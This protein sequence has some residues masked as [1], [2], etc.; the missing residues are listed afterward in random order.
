[1]FVLNL[2]ILE[3]MICSG[4]MKLI[5]FARKK[6]RF[7]LY[8]IYFIAEKWSHQGDLNSRPADYKSAALPA[9]LWWHRSVYF[10]TSIYHFFI[11]AVNCC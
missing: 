2:N 5:S 8:G 11:K 7:I 1:M 3:V 6:K 9:K 4:L 10:T